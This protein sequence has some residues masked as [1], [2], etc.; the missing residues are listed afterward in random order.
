MAYSPLSDLDDL[1]IREWN[2]LTS[3]IEKTINL[4][5]RIGLLPVY[6]TKLC[7]K[8]HNNWYLG[9]C[10]KAADKCTIALIDIEM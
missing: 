10:A 8:K 7:R 6:L 2:E 1:T 9:V 4:C 3:T 5:Q